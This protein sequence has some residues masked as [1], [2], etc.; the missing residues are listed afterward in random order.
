MT[1]CPSHRPVPP[2]TRP[3]SGPEVRDCFDADPQVEDYPFTYTDGPTLEH[4]RGMNFYHGLGEMITAMVDA[5]LR[6]EFVHE[7]DEVSGGGRL[8]MASCGGDHRT[9]LR[10]A[11]GTL[12]VDS[13]LVSGR[14]L[15]A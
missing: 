4:Q 15:R 11:D 12:P 10:R 14:L 3:G 7:H 5:G 13:R 1:G 6:I 9:R 8:L 2:T